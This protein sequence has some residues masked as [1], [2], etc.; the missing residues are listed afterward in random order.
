M[1]RIVPVNPRDVDWLWAN[2]KFFGKCQRPHFHEFHSRANASLSHCYLL[3]FRSAY[4]LWLY[5]FVR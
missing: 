1:L 2:L 5:Q 4:Q 3:S